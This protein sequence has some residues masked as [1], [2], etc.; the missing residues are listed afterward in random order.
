MIITVHVDADLAGDKLKRGSRTGFIVYLNQVPIY[1]YSKKQNC[2]ET[3]TFGAEFIAMKQ[4]CE[5]IRGLG[6]KLRMFGIPISQ[7][8][9]VYGDN[10]AVLKNAT[11]P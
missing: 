10:Q 8:A 6:Y 1:F 9:F 2:I 7:P 5:Y 11:L 3:G 4:C